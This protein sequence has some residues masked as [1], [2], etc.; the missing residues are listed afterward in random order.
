MFLIGVILG[1]VSAASA[2]AIAVEVKPAAN[3]EVRAIKSD[4]GIFLWINNR[5]G[6]AQ[7]NFQ[8][9]VGGAGNAAYEWKTFDTGKGAYGSASKVNPSN[10]ELAVNIPTLAAGA[11]MALWF[12]DKTPVGVVYRET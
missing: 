1:K 10:G 11:D 6:G 5:I 3:V 12:A 9:K 7:N 4:R 8:V 2:A